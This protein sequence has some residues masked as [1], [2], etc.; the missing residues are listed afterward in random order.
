MSPDGSFIVSA[1]HG[2]FPLNP[3]LKVWDTVT[4]AERL[5]LKGHTGYVMSCAVSPDNRFIVSA[6]WDSTLKVWDAA[7]GIERLTLTGHTSGVRRCAVSPNG[8][9]IISVSEDQTLK[10][11]DVQ[12]GQCLL[13]F[14]A[15]GELHDCAFHPDGEH[16]VICGQPGLFFLRLVV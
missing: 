16:L 13:T 6:S 10:V 7:T 1:S 2:E 5:T 9:F 15:D 4:G 12:T 8:R 3:T 11:W 14:P